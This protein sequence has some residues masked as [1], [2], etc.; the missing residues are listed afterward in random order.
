MEL[1][2]LLVAAAVR[3]PAAHVAGEHASWKHE[4]R[5][6]EPARELSLATLLRWCGSRHIHLF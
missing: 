5:L 2:W 4:A 1:G 3:L 6:T